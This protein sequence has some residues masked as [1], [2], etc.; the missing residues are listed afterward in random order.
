MEGREKERERN[1]DP[2]PFTHTPTGD[3]PVTRHVLW[4]G[5]E[6]ATFCFAGWCPTHWAT[7][8]RARLREFLIHKAERF[9]LKSITDLCFGPWCQCWSDP[10]KVH[11]VLKI[12][13]KQKTS[14]RS[15]AD[16][17][18]IKIKRFLWDFNILQAGSKTS[19][20]T[21]HSLYLTFLVSYIRAEVKKLSREPLP[22]HR[23]AYWSKSTP[24]AQ[25]MGSHVPD[26]T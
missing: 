3:W 24:R 17:R 6:P 16:L 9:V 7:P 21:G 22:G 12:L 20:C 10:C 15:R 13:Y 8:V 5:I 25:G 23:R 4:L 2:L 11:Q 26:W 1:I 19:S 18:Q 14:T